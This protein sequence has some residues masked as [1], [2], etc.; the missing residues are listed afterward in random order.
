MLFV[1][2]SKNIGF[3]IAQWGRQHLFYLFAS[4]QPAG[5]KAMW[6]CCRAMIMATVDLLASF[7]DA[8]VR[9]RDPCTRRERASAAIGKPR[10]WYSANGRKAFCFSF[11]AHNAIRSG[12]YCIGVSRRS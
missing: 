2:S 8:Y 6:Q 4:P 3:A 10:S 5:W 11:L 9:E 7:M 1:A 12:E